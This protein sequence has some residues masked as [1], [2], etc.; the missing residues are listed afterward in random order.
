MEAPGS[1]PIPMQARSS[2]NDEPRSVAGFGGEA[3]AEG[4]AN[5]QDPCI[6]AEPQGPREDPGT[7]TSVAT[8][9]GAALSNFFQRC[10][11]EPPTLPSL[12]PEHW[13]ES[14]GL[15]LLDVGNL[16]RPSASQA[17]MQPGVA[18]A[19]SGLTTLPVPVAAPAFCEE[20]KK[21]A[22]LAFAVRR[23][24]RAVLGEDQAEK[25]PICLCGLRKGQRVQ[26]LP[27]LH[28]MHG[29]CCAKYL[30]SQDVKLACPVCR[31]DL[32]QIL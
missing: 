23:S 1:Q 5:S 25:C 19:I 17:Q 11:E 16:A 12:A 24:R 7:R 20:R 31:F 28:K 26:I 27:C 4:W 21:G 14:S 6:D 32:A 10:L 22:A 18:I 8:S 9:T 2:D 13:G 3:A 30:G 29:R 15:A